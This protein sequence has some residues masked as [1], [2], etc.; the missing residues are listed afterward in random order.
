[1][2]RLLVIAGICATIALVVSALYLFLKRDKPA[3]SQ[4]IGNTSSVV[5]ATTSTISENTSDYVVDATYPQFGISQL[6]MHIRNRITDEA[7][8]LKILAAKDQPSKNRF[9]QYGY[10]ATSDYVY[11]DNAVI[12]VSLKTDVYT[13]GAH[14]MSHVYGINYDRKQN[15][16]L[17]LDDG[18]EM[19]GVTLPQAAV[20]AKAQVQK[21]IPEL[22]NDALFGGGFNPTR[23]NY[24]TFIVGTSTVTFIFQPYQVAAYA[25]G[26][27]TASFLRVK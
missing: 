2:Q 27:P 20:Q 11:S 26:M 25:A 9:P 15:R 5:E 19:I 8:E 12:S 16:L 6:D 14:G 4:S 17:T 22:T 3:E 18:L 21:A 24:Q 1:M 7:Q 13:G 23:E 10:F